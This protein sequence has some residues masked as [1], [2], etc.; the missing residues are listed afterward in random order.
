MIQVGISIQFIFNFKFIFGIFPL[1]DGRE[2]GT[3][4]QWLSNDLCKITDDVSGRQHPLKKLRLLL[5]MGNERRASDG[6]IQHFYRSDRDQP[7][8]AVKELLTL[9]MVN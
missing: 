6:E 2:G 8:K 1:Q 7:K 4:K 9:W 3:T 5:Y